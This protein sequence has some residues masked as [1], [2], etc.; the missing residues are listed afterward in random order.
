ML[1]VGGGA[2]LAGAGARP[3]VRAETQLFLH[4][5][6]A[7]TLFGSVAAVAVLAFVGRSRE[8]QLPLARASF[9]TLLALALPAWVVMLVFGEWTKSDMNWPDGLGWIDLGAGVANL[10]L[11]VLLAA[12]ALNYVWTRRPAGGWPVTVLG[13]LTGIYLVALAVAWWAMSAKVPS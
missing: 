10:G 5:L 6:G 7:V 11:F 2:G 12:A 3:D 9:F 8:E 1:W 4:I 13:A